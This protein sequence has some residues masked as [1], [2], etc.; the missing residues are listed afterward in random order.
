MAFASLSSS[1]RDGSYRMGLGELK[2][3]TTPG[4]ARRQ[5]CV[6]TEWPGGQGEGLTSS[7]NSVPRSVVFTHVSLR[8]QRL[9]S[10]TGSSLHVLGSLEGHP[11]QPRLPWLPE[12]DDKNTH[13]V[14]PFSLARVRQAVSQE[15]VPVLG[16]S[17]DTQDSKGA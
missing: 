14:R 13:L 6:F 7:W 8:S 1:L 12:G 3:L 17:P 9:G 11:K 15:R 5:G 10:N 16:E 4:G 2:S